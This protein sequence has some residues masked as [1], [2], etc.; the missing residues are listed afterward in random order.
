MPTR[1]EHIQYDAIASGELGGEVSATQC[2]D[3]VC[4]AVTLKANAD[5]TGNVY[6]GGAGV[7]VAVLQPAGAEIP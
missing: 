5:N 7:T 2:P 1:N 3:L 4:R 6:I